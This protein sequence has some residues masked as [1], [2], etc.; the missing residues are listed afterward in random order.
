MPGV[1]LLAPGAT[2]ADPAQISVLTNA[3]VTA[4]DSTV[5]GGYGSKQVT[6]VVNASLAPSGGSPALT[7][8]LQEVDPGDLT[9]PM[10]PVVTTGVIAGI[11]VHTISLPATMAGAVKVTWTVTGTFPGV[12]A[13]VS[14]KDPGVLLVRTPAGADV[15]VAADSAG[16]LLIATAPATVS[17]STTT[18]VSSAI[19]NVTLLASKL[20]RAGATIFNASKTL[21]YVKLGPVSTLVDFTVL[22]RPGCYYEVPYGFVGQIDG[23]WDELDLSGAARVTELADA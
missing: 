19:T 18:S 22:V 20:S 5:L 3:T 13:T 8:T 9:T 6:L 10:G 17:G 23:I 11:G 12:Y 15:P 21:L 14:E 1:F 16:H 4:A 2:Y 7:F